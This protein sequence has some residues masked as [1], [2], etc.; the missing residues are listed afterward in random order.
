MLLDTVWKEFSDI[1]LFRF[2]LDT[3]VL[4]VAG[5][6]LKWTVSVLAKRNRRLQKN[7]RASGLFNY[8]LGLFI[9]CTFD[10]PV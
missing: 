6:L 3:V 4:L 1:H 9:R 2:A 7:G 10:L 5:K 8:K